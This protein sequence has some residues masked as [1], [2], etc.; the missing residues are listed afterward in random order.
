MNPI[1]VRR[2][3]GTG[4]AKLESHIPRQT[5]GAMRFRGNPSDVGSYADNGVK[6]VKLWPD[7][8]RSDWGT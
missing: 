5:L 7:G 8:V 4:C 6:T 1:Q 2:I 3:T